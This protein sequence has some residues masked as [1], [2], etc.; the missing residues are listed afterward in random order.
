M[1]LGAGDMGWTSGAYY[2]QKWEY[3]L[4]EFKGLCAMPS[5]LR[6]REDL[7]GCFVLEQWTHI[8]VCVHL[9]AKVNVRYPPLFTL[10]LCLLGIDWFW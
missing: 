1:A 3:L 7:I 10:H 5:S 4:L 8:C 2:H 9:V 6:A